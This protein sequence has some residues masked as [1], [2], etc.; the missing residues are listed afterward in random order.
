MILK[1]THFHDDLLSETY[2]IQCLVEWQDGIPVLV[3]QFKSAAYD[4][5]EPLL[6]AE[7]KH[8]ERGWL[9]QPRIEV[10]LLLADNVITDHVAERTFFLPGN[11][12]D[13]IRR[14][15]TGSP[16]R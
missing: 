12:A 4:F 6:P 5:S 14:M 9:E 3:F 7:L 15:L 1:N 11:D 10:R 2:P 8:G 13:E 16:V